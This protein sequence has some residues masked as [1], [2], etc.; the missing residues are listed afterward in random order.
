MFAK[1]DEELSLKSGL[2]YQYYAYKRRK[3]LMLKTIKS[4]RKEN[5][6]H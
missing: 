6:V 3:S 4:I 2:V 1:K 5:T